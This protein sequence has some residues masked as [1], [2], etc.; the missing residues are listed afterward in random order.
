M[1]QD[2]EDVEGIVPVVCEGERV[3]YCIIVNCN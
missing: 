2:F 1:S 3:N